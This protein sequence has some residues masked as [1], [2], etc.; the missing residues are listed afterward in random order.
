MPSADRDHILINSRVRIPTSEV[1]FRFSRSSGP[2]GQNINKV[3]TRV[4]L[5]FDLNQTPSLT[6][7]QKARLLEKLHTR[8]DR[9]GVLRVVSS[10]HRT[11]SANR[12]AAIQ[13][14]AMLLAEALARPKPRIR[15]RV[16]RSTKT[17]RL[18][19]KKKRSETKQLRQRPPLD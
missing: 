14:F 16:P 6:T 2:G 19:D 3:S 7:G 4:T 9:R 5:L 11:Q 10:R 18:K 12:A 13:R 8:I 1:R 15:T 17:R